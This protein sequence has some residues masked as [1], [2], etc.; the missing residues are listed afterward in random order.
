V[1]STPPPLPPSKP[2]TV[3]YQR[4]LPPGQSLSG[5][6]TYNLVSD[7]VT[8]VNVRWKDNVYQLLAGAIVSVVAALCVAG[9]KSLPF[10]PA[11]IIGIIGGFVLGVFGWGIFLAIYR[12]LRHA[13]GKHD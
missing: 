3:E 5:S 12:G 6:Q 2:P 4:P 9:A 11:I 1:A 10:A 7:T 13:R 8:G